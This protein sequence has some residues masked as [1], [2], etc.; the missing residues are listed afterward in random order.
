MLMREARTP[1]AS[2]RRAEA[3]HA[4]AREVGWK[5]SR[6]TNA[7]QRRTEAGEHAVERIPIDGIKGA[8]LPSRAI[9]VMPSQL[10]GEAAIDVLL[11]LHGFTPGYATGDDLGVYKIEAQMAAAGKELLGI[12]PQGSEN[13][14][15]NGAADGK[16]FDAD[17]FIAAVFKRLT[18]EGYGVPA[19]G[20]VIMSSHSGGDQPLTETL[21]RKPPEKLAGLFLFDTMIASAFGGSV[22]AYVDGRI[23]AE[24]EHLKQMRLADPQSLAVEAQMATWIQ[25]NGFRL[26]VVYRKGGAYQAAAKAIEANLD[27]RFAALAKELG[28][29]LVLE[30]MR[31]HYAV[32]EVTETARIQHMDVLAGDDALRKAIETLPTPEALEGVPR[33]HAEGRP[34][35]DIDVPQLMRLASYGGNHAISRLL[36]RDTA[37]ATETVTVTVR[38]NQTEPPKEYLKDAFDDHPVSWKAD[39]YVD[40]KKAGSGDGSLDLELVKGSKHEVKIVPTGDD[41]YRA[42]SKKITAEAG[43]KDIKLGYNRENRN[44]T[45]QSWEH[46]GLDA[47]KAGDVTGD[48]LLGFRVTVNKLV[49]PTVTKTNN[50][51]NSNKLTDADRAEIKA[52]LLFIQ[53]YN[54]RTT[55]TGAFSNHSTGCAIDMNVNEA[56]SQNDHFKDDEGKFKSR[57][58]LFAHVVGR[59]SGW[60]SW[61]GW[62]EKDT[63]KWLEASRL[64]NVHFPLFLSELLDDVKGGNSNTALAQWGEALDWMA[65]TTGMVGRMLVGSQDAT[66]LRTAAKAAEKAGKPITAKWLEKTADDWPAI[67]GWIEGV[68]MYDTEHWAYVSEHRAKVAAGTEKRTPKGELHGMIPLH[69]K[70]VETLEAGG[71]TWLVDLQHAKDFMHFEDR[72]AFAALQR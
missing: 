3:N 10:S 24:L 19:P 66:K 30:S 48:T 27:A 72:A 64:F 40:G 20:R 45:D 21:K 12:L 8:G 68:V 53:G 17:A 51:F 70:L 57:M 47:T 43:T 61:D 15:F 71:W 69:P 14:D 25:Q 37:L 32:H 33:E 31:D 65:D 26:M 52:S 59:E 67:R 23:T 5:G 38:W 63:K 11:H 29:P 1:S 46:Q 2:I 39:V 56:T 22:W 49:Q 34:M 4:L 36:A 18:D 60:G 6:G 41:Y 55:S 54:R 44:F 7:K 35:D 16:A 50:Y 58:E 9:V 13:S 62:A 42:A 28:S